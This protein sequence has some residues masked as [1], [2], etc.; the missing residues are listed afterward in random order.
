MSLN[1]STTIKSLDDIKNSFYI[2]LEHRTDR[3]EHVEKEL[4]KIGIKATRF[5][6]IKMTN[7]A[8]GCSYLME[9]PE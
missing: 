2:N 5:N 1:S 6:A 4:D 9:L 3:R 7:G 8:I